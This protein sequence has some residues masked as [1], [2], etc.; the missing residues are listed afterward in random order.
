MILISKG[1]ISAMGGGGGIVYTAHTKLSRILCKLGRVAQLKRY[2]GVVRL[3]DCSSKDYL[4][5]MYMFHPLE[6]FNI[7][8][9]PTSC[10]C[11]LNKK[12]NCCQLDFKCV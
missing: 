12:I 4:E 11:Q 10:I 2:E 6:G 8:Y 7:D 1:Y 3:L 9:T 5:S